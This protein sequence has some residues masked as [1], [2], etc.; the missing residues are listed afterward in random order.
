M[1]KKNNKEIKIIPKK[2]YV[3]VF[4]MII[5]TFILSLS[6]Y[7]YFNNKK[8]K[9]YNIPVIRGVV[10]EIEV[11][12]LDS[13]IKEHD[14]FLLYIGVSNNTNCR[15]LESDLKD[16]IKEKSIS[17][18]FYLN[19][20]SVEDKTNFYDSFNKKYGDN[21]K[22]SNFPA[23]IIIRDSKIYDLVERSDRS[24]FIGDIQ[25]ILDE[26]NVLGG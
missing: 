14:D 12:D 20:T 9:E 6:V 8:E 3:I 15:N 22:L 26:Y 11:K 25:R 24:L 10:P 13:F 2:N 23:F 19:I 1:Q 4:T 17:N 7:V 21:V 16:F 18:L 5:I